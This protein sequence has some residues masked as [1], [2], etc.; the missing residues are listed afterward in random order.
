[1]DGFNLNTD[2]TKIPEVN[3]P[4][5]SMPKGGVGDLA[6]KAGELGKVGNLGNLGDVSKVTDQVKGYQGD[7]K[8]ITSGNLNEL[9]EITKTI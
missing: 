1:V 4:G 5:Y 8:N 9:K 6:S 3:I 7:V 2:F